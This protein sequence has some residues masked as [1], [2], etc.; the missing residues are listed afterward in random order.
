[1]EFC[2]DA[3]ILLDIYYYHF[4]TICLISKKIWHRPNVGRANFC[5]VL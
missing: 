1:M 5:K 4:F 3:G 2:A